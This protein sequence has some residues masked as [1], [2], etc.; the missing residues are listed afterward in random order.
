MQNI[1]GGILLAVIGVC[2]A[3]APEKTWAITEKWKV[4]GSAKP[5]P[6]V[7]VIMRVVGVCCCVVGLCVALGIMK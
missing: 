5:S 7:L 2:F 1:I 6:R 3:A 4:L